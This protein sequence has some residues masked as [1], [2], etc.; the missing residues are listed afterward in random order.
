MPPDEELEDDDAAGEEEVAAEPDFPPDESPDFD[1]P[2]AE[3]SDDELLDELS[4]EEPPL[5]ESDDALLS[6]LPFAPAAAV[7]GTSGLPE[8][9]SVR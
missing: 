1:E 2:L 6:D 9:E 8:R 7:A 4:D 5:D 3:L